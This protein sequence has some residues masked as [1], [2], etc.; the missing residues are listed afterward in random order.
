MTKLSPQ[1]TSKMNY[2]KKGSVI[3]FCGWKRHQNCTMY[4]SRAAKLPHYTLFDWLLNKYLKEGHYPAYTHTLKPSTP[5]LL[6]VDTNDTHVIYPADPWSVCK[7]GAQDWPNKP[8]LC[9]CFP[10][11]FLN[12]DASN[13]KW[14]NL[15]TENV[16]NVTY[17]LQDNGALSLSGPLFPCICCTRVTSSRIVCKGPLSQIH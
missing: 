1:T 15:I 7:E 12:E 16:E 2:W 3:Y 10:L 6:R 4:F 13:Y 8:Y 5:R 9:L 17:V 14:G 11:G